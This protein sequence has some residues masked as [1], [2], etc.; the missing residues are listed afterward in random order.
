M[1]DFNVGIQAT[2]ICAIRGGQVHVLDEMKGHP[3]TET[4]A[5]ALRQKYEGH[6]IFAY[7]DPSG[8]ARKS[9]APVGVTD[10]TILQSA[11]IQVLSRQ[12]APPISDSVQAVNRMLETA[13]GKMNF[14]VHPRCKGV[15][16]SLERTKWVDNKPETAVIDKTEGIEHFSDGI[17][18]GVEYMFP[19]VSHQKRTSRGFGF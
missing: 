15:I 4:L 2:S 7:P 14:F 19:V 11:G 18:Y 5:L 10:F 6:K 8:K 9:S 17:R 13:S 3:D 12:S 16:E 1:I